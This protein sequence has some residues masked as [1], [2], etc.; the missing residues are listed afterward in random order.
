MW[1][2]NVK[3]IF[4]IPCWPV[5]VSTGQDTWYAGFLIAQSLTTQA[6]TQ[7]AVGAAK[8]HSQ[9]TNLTAMLGQYIGGYFNNFNLRQNSLLNIEN[10]TGYSGWISVSVA[11]AQI[12]LQSLKLAHF[13][14][15]IRWFPPLL[16]RYISLHDLKRAEETVLNATVPTSPPGDHSQVES[17]TRGYC[18]KNSAYIN[19]NNPIMEIE[20]Y[21][22]KCTLFYCCFGHY[23]ML[24]YKISACEVC[25][26]CRKPT[27]A[28]KNPLPI[29]ESR[30]GKLAIVTLKIQSDCSTVHDTFLWAN[31]YVRSHLGC[32]TDSVSSVFAGPTKISKPQR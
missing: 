12:G 29:A 9:N 16:F 8:H 6:S 23:R 5:R 14:S 3:N 2:S 28:C 20:H 31:T 25:M 24:S 18:A 30:T 19:K 17:P 1:K 27:E 11:H 22:G 15:D 7:P 4:H 13:W 26:I 10:N 32:G 21:K